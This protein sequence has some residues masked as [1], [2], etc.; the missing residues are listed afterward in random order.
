MRNG[1]KTGREPARLV[2]IALDTF[3][4]VTAVT[5]GVALLAG[6]RPPASMLAGSPFGSYT[7]PGLALAV[8]LGGGGLTAAALLLRRPTWGVAASALAGLMLLVFESV[9]LLVIGFTGLLAVYVGVGL[10][11]VAL[12]AGLWVAGPTRVGSSA[13]RAPA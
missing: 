6:F 7:I 1:V 4:G 11:M 13:G 10:A 12:A 9:E 5:G 3:L 2:L 8:L